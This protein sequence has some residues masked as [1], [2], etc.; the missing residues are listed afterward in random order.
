MSVEDNLQKVDAMIEAFNSHDQDRYVGLH[1]ESIIHHDPAHPEPFKG[2]AALRE[3][4]QGFAKAFPD[5]RVEKVR[6]FGQ[7]DWVSAEYTLTGTHTGPLK[8][9]G[10]ETIPATNKPVRLQGL[11][12]YKVEGGE[13]TETR[14]YFDQLGFMAQLGLVP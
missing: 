6:A 11:G 2:R 3:H 13:V 8:G 7:G 1:A 9:P 14:D 10:G 5:V 12:L 4:F